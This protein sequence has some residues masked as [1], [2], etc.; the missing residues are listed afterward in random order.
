MEEIMVAIQLVL[1]VVDMAR[2]NGVTHVSTR[3]SIFKSRMDFVSSTYAQKISFS[4][5]ARPRRWK[6][7]ICSGQVVGPSV[8]KR[9]HV[10]PFRTGVG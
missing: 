6:R 7:L 8:K 10:E 1:I 2:Y 4:L 3:L 9:P 5:E